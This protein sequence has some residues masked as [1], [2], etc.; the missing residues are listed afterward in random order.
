MGNAGY[1]DVNEAIVIG[2]DTDSALSIAARETNIYVRPYQPS[3]TTLYGGKSL[4]GIRPSNISATRIPDDNS[5]NKRVCIC[6]SDTG[7]GNKGKAV[8][9]TV[10]SANAVTF[11]DV[12][13]V[14]NSTAH[15]IPCTYSDGVIYALSQTRLYVLN[16]ALSVL[17]DASLYGS[18]TS[19]AST[20]LIGLPTGVVAVNGSTNYNA[21]FAKWNGIS[22]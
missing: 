17:D 9:A 5:G 11:G 13:T 19:G 7:D 6:F 4:S 10:D 14:I 2:F 21:V 15:Q 3:I 12:V 16:E 1:S 22:V 20:S 18:G 8:I